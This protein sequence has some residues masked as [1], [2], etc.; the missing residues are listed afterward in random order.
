MIRTVQSI[1]SLLFYLLFFLTPLI[2]FPKT[3]ELFE[4]NKMVLVYVLTVLILA[5][6][7]IKMILAKKFI[8]K[9]TFLD[10]PLLVFL[11]V[12]TASTLFSIDPRT[13]IFGYYSRFHG[14][15]LS[16]ISYSILYWAYVSN[17]NY[18]ETK[19]GVYALLA[20]ASLVSIYG[21]LQHFGIDREIWIQDVQERVFSTLGQPNWLASWLTALLPLTWALSVNS[22]IK[23]RSYRFWLWPSLSTLFFMTILYTKSRSGLLGF[24]TAD[25]VFWTGILLLVKRGL[26]NKKFVTKIFLTINSIFIILILTSGTPWTVSIFQLS[27][28]KTQ[29][30]KTP[31]S[32]QLE[33]GGTESGEIRKIV[34]RG[35]IEIFK[36]NPILGTGP[37]TF[38]HAYYKVRPVEHNLVSEWDFLYN[39]AHNEYLNF[40]ATTGPLGFTSYLFLILFSLYQLIKTSKNP[41][42][43]TSPAG[44]QKFKKN[45]VQNLKSSFLSFNLLGDLEFLRIGILAGYISILVTNF[46]G[47]SVVPVALQFFLYPAIA[48]TLS[49]S[50]IK[51]ERSENRNTTNTQKV[52]ILIVLILASYF[53]VLVLRYWY[54]D[55]L[56]AKA[57][58][59]NLQENYQSARANLEKSIKI[60]SKE[61]FYWEELS[62]ASSGIAISQSENDQIAETFSQKALEESNRAIQLSPH[63]LSLL[64]SRANL[65]IKLS[66][67]NPIYLT[68]ARNTLLTASSLAPTDAKILYNLALSYARLG[69]IEPAVE[70]LKKAIEL[71]AN[72]RNARYALALLFSDAGK[73][74]EAIS[75][76]NYILEF[77]NPEDTQVL[78]KLLEISN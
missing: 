60:S 69:E 64:V 42:I 40:A 33:T 18:K 11:A 49:E 72:Y 9:R 78:Q 23:L 15:L 8:F 36:N 44:R 51:K 52:S 70:T 25:V 39:K 31:T 16:T 55:Y 2:L 75:E 6:W 76:L 58:G 37:E 7:I 77:I 30:P 12:Q 35:A 13:S 48:I 45:K 50:R 73:R 27:S 57:K 46:F 14:G 59:Q 28:S 56:Y 22:K 47:F 67:T 68:E 74:R 62:K 4:F 32:P 34:W 66:F 21:V 71:K 19:K 10:V 65:Y 53:I 43:P 41:N 54:A 38:A 26:L 63:N 20:S 17:I 3:S 61:A 24:I 29:I 1:T 5:T